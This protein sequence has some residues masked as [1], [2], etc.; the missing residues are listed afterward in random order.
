[1]GAKHL[2]HGVMKRLAGK[3]DDATG[4]IYLVDE[5]LGFDPKFGIC[6]N[7]G[8]LTQFLRKIPLFGTCN[9]SDMV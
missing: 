3:S 8:D 5:K 7:F 2:V 1:M 6:P 4:P 9:L